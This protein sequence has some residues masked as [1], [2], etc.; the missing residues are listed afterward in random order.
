MSCEWC[1]L[2]LRMRYVDYGP[3]GSDV[4]LICDAT[5]WENGIPQARSC[6]EVVK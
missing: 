6:M 2:P 5:V 1:G 4:A 3:M